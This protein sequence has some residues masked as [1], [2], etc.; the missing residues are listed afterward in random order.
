MPEALHRTAD[1]LAAWLATAS[2]PPADRGAVALLVART[3]GDVRAFPAVAALAVG[4][5]FPG[6]RWSA[7]KDPACDAQITVLE[8][9]FAQLLTGPRSGPGDGRAALGRFGDNV[10]VDLDLSEAN[11]PAGAR[12]RLGTAICEVTAKPHTGCRK[13]AARFGTDALAFLSARKPLRLRGIHLRV[14]APGTVAVGD[15]AEVVSRG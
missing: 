14:V 8:S 1:E 15:A 10:L 5:P 2:R 4:A 7:S 12:L 9:G 13:F 3:P 11:L 6:D